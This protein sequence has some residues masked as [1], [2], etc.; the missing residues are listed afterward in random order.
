MAFAVITSGGKQ[1]RVQ[2]GDVI[3]IERLPAS[4]GPITLTSVL[5]LENDGDVQ[6]GTPTVAGASVQATVLGE[7][8][9]RKIRILTYQPKKRRR[10][11]MG[12]RQRLMRL[13]IEAI[14][15]P[16]VASA[17]GEADGT[18][19]ARAA[20]DPQ[21]QAKPTVT[22]APKSAAKPKAEAKP[23]ATA[24]PKSAAKPKAK[25]KAKSSAKAKRKSGGK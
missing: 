7:F 6:I 10:R 18:G 25:A 3:E 13:R 9:S 24:E 14:E 12:H 4:P 17:R 5:M 16:G 23:T 2:P 15:G 11:R 21:A 8:K 19:V 20:A 22:A 1:Y